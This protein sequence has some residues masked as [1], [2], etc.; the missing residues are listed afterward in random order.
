[1]CF[2]PQT[3]RVA[4]VVPNYFVFDCRGGVSVLRGGG[5][6]VW[7]VVLC[8]LCL[9]SASLRPSRLAEV[10]TGEARSVC[11]SFLF[12]NFE[13]EIKEREIAES[14]RVSFSWLVVTIDNTKICCP[15]STRLTTRTRYLQYNTK[16]R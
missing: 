15:Q 9:F 16:S 2:Q 10:E 12:F 8:P 14:E 7:R 1:M 3:V 4:I 13:R 5:S 11:C 6:G